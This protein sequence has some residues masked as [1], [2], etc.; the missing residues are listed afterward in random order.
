ML[1]DVPHSELC[2]K[3]YQ[4]S[5]A[6]KACEELINLKECGGLKSPRGLLGAALKGACSFLRL[7][8]VLASGYVLEE[9]NDTLGSY[10]R[11]ALTSISGA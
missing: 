3:D 1:V 8:K 7:P 4:L 9:C 5:A 11:P 10:I 2:F 6:D